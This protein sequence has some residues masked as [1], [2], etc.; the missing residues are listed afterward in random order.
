MHIIFHYSTVKEN[1]LVIDS[2]TIDPSVS[3]D[4]ASELAT[5]NIQY[6]DAPVSGGVAINILGLN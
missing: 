3:K 1:S 4:I 2:S 5:K 6:L